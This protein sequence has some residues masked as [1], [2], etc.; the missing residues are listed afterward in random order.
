MYLWKYA[1]SNIKRNKA[2]NL[3]LGI[4]LLMMVMLSGT[5][6]I[7]NSGASQMVELYKQQFTT[8]VML[9]SS[10][11]AKRI[12]PSVQL[13]FSSSTLLH[14][15]HYTAKLAM[16][17]NT[18]KAVGEEVDITDLSKFYVVASSHQDISEEF[19]QKTK[20]I[21]KGQKFTKP[22]EVLI[23][24][25]VSELNKLDVG[26]RIVMQ[27]KGDPIEFTISGIYDDLSLG[28]ATA[29]IPLKNPLNEIYIN[30]DDLIKN[31][32]F[33]R[34]GELN[35]IFF[36]KKPSDLKAFQIEIKDKGLPAGYEVKS[37]VKGYE[38]AIAPANSIRQVATIFVS[39]ILIVGLFLILLLSAF[40]IRERKYEVG[41]LRAMGMYKRDIIKTFM[42]ETLII[43]SICLVIGL[44]LA[45]VAGYLFGN[46]LFLTEIKNISNFSR[47]SFTMNSQMIILLS[48]V[49]IVSQ[50]IISVLLIL[51]I[52]RFEPRKILSERN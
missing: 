21:I 26:T 22:N 15:Y 3:L 39:G 45:N 51:S 37:D 12:E 11:T 28:E 4:I 35:S 7:V 24:K 25:N 46:A 13:S 47:I 38:E 32:L 43:C 36:L 2:R 48:L 19:R 5:A 14:S 10:L 17:T 23:S 20:V 16:S 41:V 18:L 34:Y 30:Y 33:E 49:M 50:F 52:V 27:V 6:L 31:N 40:S 9:H 1:F 44:I 8:K 29:T 42:V